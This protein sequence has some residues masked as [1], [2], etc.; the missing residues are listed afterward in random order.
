MIIT[1][2]ESLI[3]L[4]VDSAG[5]ITPSAGGSPY[6]TA[7]SISR[8]GGTCAFLGRFGNDRFGRLLRSGLLDDGVRLVC[9]EPIDAP[10]TLALAEIGEGGE[11]AYH[12]YLA[13]TAAAMV[14]AADALLAID[15]LAA[16]ATRTRAVHVGSL[17]LAMEPVAGS[18]ETLIGTLPAD[19]LVT[20]DPNCRPMA[21]ADEDA[22]KRR[23]IRLSSRVDVIK[24][25]DADLA[26][27]SPG[28]ST[29]RAARSL[30]SGGVGA[31]IVTRGSE[32]AQAITLEGSVE[33]PVP[34]I[35]VVDT[36]GAGDSFGG[37]FLAWWVNQG[38]GRD[39]VRDLG[40]LETALSVATAVAAMTCQRV[41]ADPPRLR[42][43][44]DRT[45]EA[46]RRR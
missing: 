3:D 39:E 21:I 6:N 32:P 10:T 30:L 13:E 36:I 31:V 19:V 29:E 35:R 45:R 37:A 4:V 7:R 9:P 28:E 22:Y 33:V 24:V 14:S 8:L 41:G 16:S 23:L 43:L 44:D 42:E 15:L 38:L 40:A 1:A 5:V 17:G 18:L 27:L 46:W 2:G 11:A 26:Y 25:S 20:M 12:F 34:A